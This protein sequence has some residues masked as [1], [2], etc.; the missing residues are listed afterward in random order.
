MD[1]I[2]LQI[3]MQNEYNAV[4]KA[5]KEGSEPISLT[6]ICDCARH[7]FL[8][9]I[10]QDTGRLMTV[11]TPDEKSSEELY[12]SLSGIEGVYRFPSRDFSFLSVDA[13][14]REFSNARLEVLCAIFTGKAKMVISSIESACQSTATR[15]ELKDNVKSFSLY[16]DYPIEELNEYLVQHG[17][18]HSEK[19]EGVGQFCLRG[20]ILDFFPPVEKEPLRLEFFGD[21]IDRISS[22]DLISQRSTSQREGFILCPADEFYADPKKLEKVRSA[23]KESL[24]SSPDR[25]STKK[26]LEDVEIGR[27]SSYDCFNNILGFGEC[28]LDHCTEGIFAIND[29]DLCAE[30]HKIAMELLKETVKSLTEQERLPIDGALSLPMVE[31]DLFLDIM[32]SSPCALFESFAGK[33]LIP[34]KGIFR[35]ESRVAPDHGADLKVLCDIIKGYL[36][37]ERRIFYA[38]ANS[39]ARDNLKSFLDNSSIPCSVFEAGSDME[40]SLHGMV[41]IYTQSQN[42]YTYSQGFELPKTKTVFLCDTKSAKASPKKQYA[43]KKSARETIVSYA[44]LEKG[45]YVVHANHGIG[46]YDGIEKIEKDGALR[47]FIKIKYAGSDVLYVPCSNLENV[48]KY[49]GAGSDSPGLKLNKMGTDTWTKTKSRA[50]S[51]VKDIAKDLIKLY[52]ARNSRKGHAFSTDSPWQKEFEDAFEYDPTADQIRSSDEIKM[53]MEKSIPMDRLLCGDV[54]FGKTEIALRAVFKC[55][56]D[57]MQAAILVPTTILAWQHYQTVLSRFRS[58]PV[59]VGLLNRFCTP[60]EVKKT[61]SDLKNGA[62]DIVVGTHR[63]LQKDVEFY[64][65]GLLVVDE[66]QRF[67]VAHKE[68]IK[69]QAQT[70]DVLTLTATPIP[71]TLN[72]ALGGIR[73]MSVLEEAPGDRFPVQTYVTE[74]DRELLLEAIRKELRRSGQVFWLHNNTEEL[75][76]RAAFIKEAFPDANVA[77]AHG[78]MDKNALNNIWKDMMD[79]KVDVLVCT[80]IIETGVDVANANTLIVEDADHFGLSQLHQIRGRVGRS[81]RKAYA[82][83]CYRKGKELSEI[84]RKRLNAIKEYTKFGSGF[85][86]ALRDLELRGAGNLLGSQQHGHIESVG[87]DLC[88]QLLDSAVKEEKGE[89]LSEKKDCFIDVAADAYIPSSYLDSSKMRIDVYKEISCADTPEE[90]EKTKESLLDR[91]GTLPKAVE[92]LFLIA[93]LKQKA[94]KLDITKISQQDKKLIFFTENPR[95]KELG[96]VNDVYGARFTLL[97]TGKTRFTLELTSNDVIGQALE[98]LH[99]YASFSEKLDEK[100]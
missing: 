93:L 32:K 22:F 64:S 7:I 9:C 52:A 61:L 14:S 50:K 43:V 99:H 38:A 24:R 45:D 10:A 3:R 78:K 66:E 82:F 15:A 55:I 69:E 33:N 11:I 5:M 90:L 85:K 40:G 13:S 72:M 31:M 89:K 36:G 17:Y 88:M 80:T 68:K 73:D 67:G 6:G 71:R 56:M 100:A 34:P 92:N 21:T 97:F 94:Q 58:Y 47:D 51:A 70:V 74:Y 48:S 60:K 46:I 20:G 42:I 62:L 65:L 87:Y 53:D 2:S 44:D 19:V 54:G 81:D 4:V 41:H 26:A 28:L 1:H 63:L 49:I 76:S 98:I 95:L 25:E 29:G 18:S 77:V 23:L 57:G 37:E 27:I 8:S 12:K 91:F 84:S 59:K 35:F 86:L 75:Y 96:A 83:F 30:R 79:Q 16:D 39:I